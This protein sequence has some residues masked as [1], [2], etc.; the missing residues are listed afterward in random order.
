MRFARLLL[1]AVVFAAPGHVCLGQEDLARALARLAPVVGEADLYPRDGK[2][3]IYV[4]ARRHGLSASAIYN[5]NLGDLLAGHELLLLPLAYLPPQPRA[6]GIV[7]NLAER[8]LYLYQNG[9]PLARFPVAIGMPGWETPTGDYTIIN[10]AKNPTWFP[11]KWAIQE[12]PVPPGPGNP[13]GDRWMGLSAPGYGIHATN[14]PSSIGRY[15][16]HGCLRMYPEHA[17]ELYEQ[18]AVGTPVKIVYQRLVLGFDRRNRTVCLSYYPDPYQLRTVTVEDVRKRLKEFGLDQLPQDS[19]LAAALERPRGAPTPIIGSRVGV[20]V[21]GRP[22]SLALS[23][24]PRGDDWLVPAEPLAKALHAKLDLGP[25]ASYIAIT[26][27]RERLLLSPGDCF[28]IV[29]GK[30]VEL[31][32]APEV[33]A[34]HPMIPVRATALAL[35]ASVGWDEATETVLVWDDSPP[36]RQPFSPGL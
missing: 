36:P 27:G 35:A 14:A 25:G 9:R 33:A 30:M 5:A 26:R 8:N 2:E 24:V 19:A 13:L 3:P 10:K 34:G 7:V 21:N 23:P 6:E 17:H 31:P 28:A 11:P 4:I 15:V 22:L 20:S 1:L 32:C 16:S 18:V 12:Q 29:R